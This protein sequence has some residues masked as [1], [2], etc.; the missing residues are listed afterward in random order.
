MGMSSIDRSRPRFYG[1][2]GERIFGSNYRCSNI[3]SFDQQSAWRT[4]E[5]K[6]EFTLNSMKLN[7]LS[8]QLQSKLLCE[9]TTMK[10]KASHCNLDL[11]LSLGLKARN[12]E[13]EKSFEDKEEE[14]EEEEE[15]SELCLSLYS[16]SSLKVRRLIKE[17]DR[18]ED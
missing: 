6:H 13:N 15:E 3:S 8:T 5:L 10:R 17:D 4:H 12:E 7:P 14:E 18:R 9:Q 2:I 1:T 11:S 16:P